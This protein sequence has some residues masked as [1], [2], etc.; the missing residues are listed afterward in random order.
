MGLSLHSA[1][2]RSCAKQC[3]SKEKGWWRWYLHLLPALQRS[4]DIMNCTHAVFFA[5]S[6]VRGKPASPSLLI[7]S[8]VK[9]QQHL[10]SFLCAFDVVVILFRLDWC[11]PNPR[12]DGFTCSRV[13]G[14]GT[15]G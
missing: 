8:Q 14:A 4:L 13:L 5:A 3:V 12:A 6:I 1:R 15:C 11:S 9:K 2:F 10:A 7:D